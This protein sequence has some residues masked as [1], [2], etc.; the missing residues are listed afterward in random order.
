MTTLEG[1]AGKMGEGVDG[2]VTHISGIIISL[3]IN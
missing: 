3:N 1:V 2:G